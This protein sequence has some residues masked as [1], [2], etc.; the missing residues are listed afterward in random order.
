[1]IEFPSKKAQTLSVC[2]SP[3]ALRVKKK[4]KKR[5]P[6]S[7]LAL[8]FSTRW[9]GNNYLLEDGLSGVIPPVVG[10]GGH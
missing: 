4:I 2:L 1:M 5:F 10:G 7:R 3:L 8:F 6:T 9:T